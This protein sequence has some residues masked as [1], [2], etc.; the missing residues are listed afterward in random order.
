MGATAVMT[1]MMS[2]S[3]WVEHDIGAPSANRIRAGRW[4]SQ[5]GHESQPVDC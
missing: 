1:M 3:V 5:Y 2:G 4:R